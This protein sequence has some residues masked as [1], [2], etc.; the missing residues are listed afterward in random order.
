MPAT[1]H[2]TNIENLG[3]AARDPGGGPTLAREEAV[4]LIRRHIAMETLRTSDYDDDLWGL[5]REETS[6]APVG[7][8]NADVLDDVLTRVREGE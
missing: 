1:E 3:R 8:T 2:S 5:W 7:A 6:R 4:A